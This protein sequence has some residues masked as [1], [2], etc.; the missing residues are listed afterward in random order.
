MSMPNIPDITPKI[1]ITFEDSVNLLLHSIAE[2]EISLSKLID[3]EK[4]KI[5]FVSHKYKNNEADICDLL[6]VNDSVDKTITDIIKLQMLL[7]FKLD[8][9]KNLIPEITP[10]PAPKPCCHKPEHNKKCGKSN[11][12]CLLTGKCK[13]EISNQS[14][15]FYCKRTVLD[16]FVS[17]YNCK[18]NVICYYAGDDCESLCLTACSNNI[19]IECPCECEC[20]CDKIKLCGSATL[21]KISGQ[22]KDFIKSNFELTVWDSKYS[23]FEK[24]GFHMI[25]LPEPPE[26]REIIHDSGFVCGKGLS[27]CCS[28]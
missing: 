23:Q 28:G 13:G 10:C 2:E 24:N 7:Q 16:L 14:D 3:A 15:E 1:N 11:S 4:D 5:L 6:S 21:T 18:N 27:L 26:C 12:W 17:S 25:I 8:S 19:K 22:K 20:E 9:V